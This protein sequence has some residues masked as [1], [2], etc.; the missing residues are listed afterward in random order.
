M[1]KPDAH[2]RA[3]QPVTLAQARAILSTASCS[4]RN[5][6]TPSQAASLLSGPINPFCRH[7]GLPGRRLESSA[8]LSDKDAQV[9]SAQSAVGTSSNTS[10]DQSTPPSPAPSDSHQEQTRKK[11]THGHSLITD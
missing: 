8:R 7:K 1:M 10:S 5:G 4:Y 2:D 9:T 3:Y 6:L 11:K